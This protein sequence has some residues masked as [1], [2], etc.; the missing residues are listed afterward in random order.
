MPLPLPRR[1]PRQPLL[2]PEAQLLPLLRM[3]AAGHG[4]HRPGDETPQPRLP[5][6]VPMARRCGQRVSGRNAPHPTLPATRPASGIPLRPLPALLRAPV[7]ERRGAAVPLRGEE[8]RP[9]GGALVPPHLVA[10]PRGHPLAPDT[11]LL[12]GGGTHR[13]AE[14]Q[15]RLREAPGRFRH[16]E[17]IRGT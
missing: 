16:G 9:Q 8:D 11:L 10:G 2:Q 6:G 5:Q 15:P 17:F 13:R 7:A 4:Q 12:H 14:P 3:H 1:P